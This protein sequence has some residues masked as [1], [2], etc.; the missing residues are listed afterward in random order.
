MAIFRQVP[1][2]GHQVDVGREKIQFLT[3]MSLYLRNDT[4]SSAHSD[5]SDAMISASS[6]ENVDGVDIHCGRYRLS[7]VTDEPAASTLSS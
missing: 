3:N 6:S 7:T 2:M 1:P 5:V 4:M